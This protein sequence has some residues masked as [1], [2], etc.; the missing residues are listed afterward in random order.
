MREYEVAAITVVP[1]QSNLTDPVFRHAAE[2][3]D[4]P[5]FARKVAGEWQPV[6]C[7]TFAAEVL[8]LAAGLVSAGVGPGDR[9]ALL[10][11]TRYEWTLCDYA[12]LSAG[13]VSVPVYETSSAEQVR[14]MLG[15]S[16]AI[17][18]IVESEAHA[19][20]V[21]AVRAALPELR[22]VWR[23]EAG[24]L[25]DL[26][27]RGSAAGTESVAVRRAALNRASL[28][29]V[30]YTSGTTGRPKGCE[31]TH[32]NLLAEAAVTDAAPEVFVGST[33]VFLP[34][35][36]VLARAIQ[37]GCMAARV[38]LGHTPDIADLPA[39]LLSF[40]PS[41]VLA[42]PR[43]FEK[44]YNSA[45]TRAHAERKG[46]IFDLADR[47]AVAYSRA[48]DTGGPPLPLRLRHALLDRL[49]YGRLRAALGG[50]LRY[51]VSGGAPLGPQLAHF[52]RGVGVTVLE[53]YGLTET[54]AGVTFNLPTSQRIGTV[55][56]PIPG[57]A[58]RIADDG[59][60]L[61]KGD[62]VFGGYWRNPEAT[63]EALGDGWFRTG[64][65]GALDD[66]G[67]LRIVGRKKELIVTAGG[68]NVAPA[69]LEDRL[70]AA[71]LVSQC[72]VVGDQKPFVGC[73]ITLDPDALP[74]WAAAHGKPRGVT[75]GDLRDDP[76]LRAEIQA[77]VDDA[78]RAVSRTE[79]IKRFRIL[80]V[81][82]TEQGGQLTPSLKVKR[83]VVAAEFG[84]EIEA[85]YG[86]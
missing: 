11:R 59:E 47:T 20:T 32:G 63:A 26:A 2:A 25:T 36:H 21:A 39:D 78:N 5:L 55:G 58:V 72:M 30:I 54:S 77:A 15:D 86:A 28:A 37:V 75:A 83:A 4:A 56:R 70:R 38:Q 40:R 35:A 51:A 62:V 81:D 10:S 18:V 65:L 27:A 13:A 52:F 29:T 16:G 3:P 14:W 46:A 6:S 12:I 7:A 53:G 23:I 67:F 50:R 80:P 17:A 48:L 74:G 19:D 41:F 42:V 60:V 66:D 68:K 8:A 61:I 22:E 43:V 31:L 64:D 9:V 24:D 57:A 84:A 71:A 49:V 79:A 33:L 82:F 73:L 69:V 45:T 1:A 44:I 85:I 76:D 34:L